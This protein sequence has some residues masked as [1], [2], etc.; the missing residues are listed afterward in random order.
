MKGQ[1]VSLKHTVD[2]VVD[3]AIKQGYVTTALGNKRIVSGED[4]RYWILNHYIQACVSTKSCGR[5]L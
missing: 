1:N 4:D 2:T 3:N 5:L